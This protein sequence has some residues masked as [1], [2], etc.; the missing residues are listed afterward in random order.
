[1]EKSDILRD[2]AP[3]LNIIASCIAP[4]TIL[5]AVGLLIAGL[6]MKYTALIA[7]IRA[8]AAECQEGENKSEESA[9]SSLLRQQACRTQAQSLLKRAWLVRCSLVSLYSSVLFCVLASLSVGGSAIGLPGMRF[10]VVG[11]FLTG[12]AAILL[13]I[14]YALS[15]ARQCF[16]VVSAEIHD[17][18]AAGAVAEKPAQENPSEENHVIRA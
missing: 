16:D 10:A 18:A 6:Q 13:G 3:A 11:F 14:F 17:L 9:D 8:L 2:I 12:F 5:I 4:S 7:D 1:M 15:E